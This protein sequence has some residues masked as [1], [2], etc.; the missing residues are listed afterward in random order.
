MLRG[1]PVWFGDDRVMLSQADDDGMVRVT[2]RRVLAAG[3]WPPA[4]HDQ[5]KLHSPS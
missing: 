2:V 4:P 5:V 1:L 3:A